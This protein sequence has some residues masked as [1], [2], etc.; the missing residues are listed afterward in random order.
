MKP[1]FYLSPDGE[2]I[3]EVE[4]DKDSHMWWVVDV[5]KDFEIFFCINRTLRRLMF[6]EQVSKPWIYLG[7]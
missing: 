3:V 7:E 2:E 1:G 6:S 4:V 5:K